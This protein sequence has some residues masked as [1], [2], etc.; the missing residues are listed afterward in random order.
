M[1]HTKSKQKKRQKPVSNPYAQSLQK[2]SIENLDGEVV[3]RI[4]NESGQPTSCFVPYEACLKYDMLLPDD[5][6]TAK[7]LHDKLYNIPF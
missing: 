1:T 4:L 3:A 7:I 5:L 2:V 6:L